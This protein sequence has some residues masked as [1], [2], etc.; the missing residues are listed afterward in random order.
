[1]K[2]E[3]IFAIIITVLT[4]LVTNE[5]YGQ[6]SFPGFET[7]SRKSSTNQEVTLKID[8]KSV[9]VFKT[10]TNSYYVNRVSKRTGK[11]YRYYLGKIYKKFPNNIVFV[12]SK[13]TN[14][15]YFTVDDKGILHRHKLKKKNK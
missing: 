6:T 15:Y 10:S 12:N 7:V 2:K 3:F 9:K 11:T 1:M 5:V 8:N 14:Y 4:I 13:G